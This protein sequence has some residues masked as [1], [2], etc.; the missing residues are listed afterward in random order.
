MAA[1]IWKLEVYDDTKFGTGTLNS[2]S[3]TIA[4]EAAPSALSIDDVSKAE[5]N[6]SATPFT[7]TVSLSSPAG[8]Q[9]TVNYATANGTAMEGSDYQSASG[10]LTF[11]PG[12]TSRQITVYV[13][14]DSVKESNETFAVNLSSAVGASIT[15]GQGLGTIQND[16]GRPS[17]N[18]ASSSALFDAAPMAS[19]TA[20]AKKVELSSARQTPPDPSDLPMPSV[21]LFPPMTLPHSPP[22]DTASVDLVLTAWEPLENELIDNLT[23]GLLSP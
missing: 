19:S 15:D 5:G 22:R 3:L 2:W 4:H 12:Q 6:S 21:E 18:S 14:G 10:T 23:V 16:D 9:V 1:G 11:N 7:F 8:S 13:N 17:K 20:S